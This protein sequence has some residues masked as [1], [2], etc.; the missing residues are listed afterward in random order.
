M[1]L[2]SDIDAPDADPTALTL[3]AYLAARRTVGKQS[4]GA[5]ATD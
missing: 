5:Q 3:E 4:A 1:T 2:A